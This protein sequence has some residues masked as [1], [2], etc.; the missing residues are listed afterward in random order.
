MWGYVFSDTTS[1]PALSWMDFQHFSERETNKDLKEQNTRHIQKGWHLTIIFPWL[2]S[3]VATACMLALLKMACWHGFLLFS[4]TRWLTQIFT[5]QITSRQWLWGGKCL[6]SLSPATLSSPLPSVFLARNA[7]HWSGW[8]L[9]KW[10]FLQWAWQRQAYYMT[11]F[12]VL[13]SSLT[14]TLPRAYWGPSMGVSYTKCC[15]HILWRH[16][17]LGQGYF[18]I[19]LRYKY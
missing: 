17:K 2:V 10:G 6:S 14:L 8:L 3:Y 4:A 13:F 11:C 1:M 12:S 5:L 19:V 16:L 7:W 15:A 18:K 9:N